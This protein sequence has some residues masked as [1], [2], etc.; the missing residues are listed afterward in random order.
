MCKK[1]SINQRYKYREI[2]ADR[3]KGKRRMPSVSDRRTDTVITETA[4]LS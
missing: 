2:E 4:L 1:K 3:Q